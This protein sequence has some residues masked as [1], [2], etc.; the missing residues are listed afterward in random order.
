MQQ[1]QVPVTSSSQTA[2]IIIDPAL[3]SGTTIPNGQ[4]REPESLVKMDSSENA[5]STST[6]LPMFFLP[7]GISIL[8]YFVHRVSPL[9]PLEELDL[10]FYFACCWDGGESM[11]RSTCAL[12][13]QWVSRT[14]ER[15]GN[16]ADP[17]CGPD[18]RQSATNG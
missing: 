7:H 8:E 3:T 11:I 9:C 1:H 14:R 13:Q 4:Y 18:F 5:A 12:Y 16:I 15:G 10:A 6:A 2:D 17:A